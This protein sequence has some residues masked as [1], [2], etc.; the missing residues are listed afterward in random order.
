MI[1]CPRSD[2]SQSPASKV[3]KANLMS[4]HA[5]SCCV[6]VN[7]TLLSR[8]KSSILIQRHRGAP[9]LAQ[10]SVCLFFFK[11]KRLL[12][13][14]CWFGRQLSWQQWKHSAQPQFPRSIMNFML[15]LQASRHEKAT[16]IR[17]TELACQQIYLWLFLLMR[18]TWCK[19]K[20]Q[21]TL[22]SAPWVRSARHGPINPLVSLSY[23]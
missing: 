20:L 17:A 13:S 10:F 6:L 7:F 21:K 23:D 12:P 19:R 11:C 1:S 16:I 8:Q 4:K 9:F 14:E 22:I 18:T 15:N 2:K 3:S 5:F